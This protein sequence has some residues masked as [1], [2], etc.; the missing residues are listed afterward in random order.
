MATKKNTGTGQVSPATAERPAAPEKYV[1]I[2]ELRAKHHISPALYTGVCSAQGW[3]PGKAVTERE[4]LEAIQS[5]NS[6][7]MSGASKGGRK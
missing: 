5:F 1:E 7:P 2:G 4:F 6:A 3:K